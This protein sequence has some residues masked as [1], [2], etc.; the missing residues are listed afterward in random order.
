MMENF[1]IY[2]AIFLSV[3]LA[4]A[5]IILA[6]LFPKYVTVTKQRMKLGIILLFGGFAVKIVLYAIEFIY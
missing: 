6:Q 4:G 3:E 2:I 1:L 5:L